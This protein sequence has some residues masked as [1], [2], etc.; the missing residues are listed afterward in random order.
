[1]DLQTQNRTEPI[2]RSIGIRKI[3]KFLKKFGA[4]L[5]DAHMQLFGN[6]CL[7]RQ[8]SEWDRVC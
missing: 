1:M 3:N 5:N 7:H 8:N 2:M 4:Q 6:I